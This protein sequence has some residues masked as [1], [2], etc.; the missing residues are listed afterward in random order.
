MILILWHGGM[1]Y[2]A[3]Y[4][5]VRLE[6]RGAAACHKLGRPGSRELQ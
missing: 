5:T 6:N 3:F 2:N 1:F 4:M